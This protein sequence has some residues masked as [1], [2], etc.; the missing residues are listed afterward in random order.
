MNKATIFVV[1]IVVVFAVFGFLLYPKNKNENSSLTQNAV[2]SDASV[3]LT[4]DADWNAGTHNNTKSVSGLSQINNTAS[5]EIDLALLYAQ[6]AASITQSGGVGNLNY[7]IDDDINTSWSVTLTSADQH[8]WWKIDL[9]AQ[10]QFLS[11]RTLVN[12]SALCPLGYDANISSSTNDSSYSEL[13]DA[14][15]DYHGE[16]PDGYFTRN[17]GAVGRYIMLDVYGY[18]GGY[19]PISY[20]LND[21]IVNTLPVATHTT[22]ATQIDGSEGGT[23]NLVSWETFTPTYTKPANT[24]VQFRFR[25][26]A[27][28]TSWTSWSAYQTPTSGNALDISSIVDSGSGANKYLQVEST[29][30]NTDGTSTPTLDSYS[31]SYHTNIAPSTPTA[32]TAVVGS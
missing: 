29:L 9:G 4:S 26:S 25:S 14:C 28:G 13:Y 19:F 32:M 31:A 18:V 15:G 6:N 23:K 27:D 8:M 12:S 1:V 20:G 16:D 10:Y 2:A 30:S 17:V 21:I 11:F 3:T 22:A 7:P 24:N 5:Q